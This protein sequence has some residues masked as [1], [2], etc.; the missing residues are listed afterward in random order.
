MLAFP[1]RGRKEAD[2]P[3][4]SKADLTARNSDF[5]SSPESGKTTLLMSGLC[6]SAL[7]EGEGPEPS[8]D[9]PGDGGRKSEGSGFMT[10]AYLDTC[11]QSGRRLGDLKPA[12]EMNA[13]RTLEKA[14]REGKIKIVTSRET[15]REQERT[16]DPTLRAQLVQSQGATPVVPKDH[17]LLGIHNQMDHLGT[18]CGT[19]MLTEIVDGPLFDSLIAAGLKKADADHLVYAAHPDNACDWFVTTDP[20]FTD[21]QARLENLC[22]GLRIE[23]FQRRRR[24]SRPT[25]ITVST[26]FCRSPPVV[27]PRAIYSDRTSPERE[28]MRG[29]PYKRS[30]LLW[31]CGQ[32]RLPLPPIGPLVGH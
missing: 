29:Y 26:R 6:R 30:H 27:H 7:G 16:N 25:M 3:V 24:C 31:R 21:R 12:A 18:V 4:G 20:D 14:E 32:L 23:A 10:T 15:H 28:R 17:T 2:V 19:P 8:G 11:I 1:S 9:E 5:R 22:P 13:V